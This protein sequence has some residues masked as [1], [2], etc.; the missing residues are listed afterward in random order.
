M[1]GNNFER[2]LQLVDEVFSVRNDPSQLEVNEEVME[3][4]K[5]LHPSTLS[6]Y[7]DENGPAVWI[8]LIP[9]TL[10]V[11]H[12]FLKGDITEKQILEL[13]S[14]KIPFT[15]LYLCSAIALPEYR[16]KGIAKRITTEAIES[17]MK[18]NPIK[19]FFVWPFSNEGEGLSELIAAKYKLPL[20]KKK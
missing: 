1:P 7:S 9:T 15:S 20:H 2:M 10:E 5:S 6:E 18:N 3:K 19:A 4:L 12:K 16:K 13:T 14:A 11:M 8:L 17:I